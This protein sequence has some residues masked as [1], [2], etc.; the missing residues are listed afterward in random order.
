MS[1]F[2][3]Q[4]LFDSGPYQ[5]HVGG[6]SLRHVVQDT[7]G[8]MG[9]RLSDLG[10]KGR[11]IVQEGDLIAD[12]MGALQGLIDAVEAKVDGLAHELIDDQDRSW[13]G[14]VM[15]AFEPQPVTRLGPRWRVRYRIEY[16]QVVA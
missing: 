9:V 5:F 1:S 15:L 2:D 11:A 16:L 3:G 7:P 14:V 8:G 13:P 12:D 10:T 6:M 4:A